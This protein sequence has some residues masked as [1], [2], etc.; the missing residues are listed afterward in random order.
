[1]AKANTAPAANKPPN[2]R[3]ITALRAG[4]RSPCPTAAANPDES[5]ER[6]GTSPLIGQPRGQLK[7][8]LM[9][10]GFAEAFIALKNQFHHPALKRKALEAVALRE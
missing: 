3:A 8:Q 6:T 1:V 4:V 2:A 10:V 7:Y 9:N 5:L